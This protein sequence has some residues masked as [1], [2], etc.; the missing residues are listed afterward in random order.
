MK[1]FLVFILFIG[2]LF[3]SGNTLAYYER[4]PSGYT[5]TSPIYFDILRK[6][7]DA[8]FNWDLFNGQCLENNVWEVVVR[9]K[10][11]PFYYYYFSEDI[12]CSVLGKTIEMN[13]PV[14][15]NI[16]DYVGV[17]IFTGPNHE[18]PNGD[19][20][21]EYDDYNAEPIFEI[22][23]GRTPLP[24][25]SGFSINFTYSLLAY[26]GALITGLGPLLY[27]IIGAPAGFWIIKKIIG[28]MPKK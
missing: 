4:N 14:S 12:P 9:A 21:L 25:F 13:L 20:T 16:Y 5:I 6:G 10:L 26:V 2:I 3:F 23:E 8:G 28:F 15:G 1:K 11:G 18:N 7:K 27:L 17:Q 19:K 22:T 24:V